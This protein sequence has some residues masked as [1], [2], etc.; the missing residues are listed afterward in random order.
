MGKRSLTSFGCLGLVH[1]ALHYLVV[2]LIAH[3]KMHLHQRVQRI[4]D[5]QAGWQLKFMA[6]CLI[7]LPTDVML[8]SKERNWTHQIQQGCKG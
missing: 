4:L 3:M 8:L 2:A 5:F 7:L 1:S 6:K